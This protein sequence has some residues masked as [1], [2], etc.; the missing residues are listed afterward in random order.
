V[1]LWAAN[2]AR[3]RPA[4][5]AAPPPARVAP[6]GDS[7]WRRMPRS[8]AMTSRV[9]ASRPSCNARVRSSGEAG[10]VRQLG[11]AEA[12]F[13]LSVDDEAKDWGDGKLGR[14]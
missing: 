10:S 5:R 2:A 4:N 8:A 1:R 9:S 11:V 12:Q 7:V 6:A 14:C 13:G 3:P